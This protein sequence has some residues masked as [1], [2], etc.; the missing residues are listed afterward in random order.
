MI[1]PYTDS[2]FCSND[3]G[4]LSFIRVFAVNN[5]NGDQQNKNDELIWHRDHHDRNVT[6]LEGDD[7]F[8]QKDNGLPFRLIPGQ[9][10]HIP[11]MVYHRLF[12]NSHQKPSKDLR[13]RIVEEYDH[14]T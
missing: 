13:I 5:A 2:D 9:T 12:I 4:F 10:Y 7:W 6:V 8:L 1:K 14:Q 11:S 3:D